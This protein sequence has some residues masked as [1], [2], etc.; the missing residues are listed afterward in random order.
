MKLII[1]D[2]CIRCG[3][4]VDVCANLFE[5]DKKK[6]VM[7]VKVNPIPENL[8]DCAKEAVQ[9]CAVQAIQVKE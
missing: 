2:Y 5:M 1:E 8:I 3:I 7:L 4:C 9:A 6:D